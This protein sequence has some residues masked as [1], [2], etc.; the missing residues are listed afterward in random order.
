MK[1]FLKI[2][3]KINRN[4][5]VFIFLS[6]FPIFSLAAVSSDGFV[7]SPA[8]C[9]LKEKYPCKLR[10]ASGSFAGHLTISRERQSFNLSPD[11]S[12]LFTSATQIEVMEGSL[13]IKDSQQLTLILSPRLK[14]E[15]NGQFFMER[16]KDHSAV[17]QNLNGEIKFHSPAVD[18]SEALPLGFENWYGGLTT[19]GKIQRGIIRPIQT[20]QFLKNWIPICGLASAEMKKQLKSY[21]Q[22][23][24]DT[25]EIASEMYQAVVERQLASQAEKQQR[26]SQRRQLVKK[27]EQNFRRLYREKNNLPEN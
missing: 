21:R 2:F 17:L 10:V 12:V 4:K 3:N 18:P 6:F 9:F 14:V 5:S 16:K 22:S 26:S 13:W 25:T 1:P 24:I 15:L 23:W 8:G 19:S 20:S 27:D 7:D 11:T